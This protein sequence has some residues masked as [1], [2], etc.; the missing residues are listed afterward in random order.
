MSRYPDV[1]KAIEMVFADDNSER[2]IKEFHESV[3]DLTK[4]FPDL[5]VYIGTDN[6]EMAKACSKYYRIMLFL[7]KKGMIV[8][9]KLLLHIY[10]Y[11]NAIY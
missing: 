1:V 5:L 11:L 10:N 4:D 6:D 2:K 8:Y 3:A 9:L 7:K